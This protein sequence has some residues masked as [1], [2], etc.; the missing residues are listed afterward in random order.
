MED[1]YHRIYKAT[2]EDEEEFLKNSFLLNKKIKFKI[3]LNPV[4]NYKDLLSD[5]A[6]LLYKKIQLEKIYSDKVIA[7]FRIIGDR[8]IELENNP[9]ILEKI[10]QSE[11]LK[12]KNNTNPNYKQWYFHDYG[13]IKYDATINFSLEDFPFFEMDISDIFKLETDWH[14]FPENLS[15]QTEKIREIIVNSLKHG[16]FKYIEYFYSESNQFFGKWKKRKIVFGN[17]KLALWTLNDIKGV[18]YK[19]SF[20]NNCNPHNAMVALDNVLERIYSKNKFLSKKK[21][22]LIKLSPLDLE[23]VLIDI[24]EGMQIPEMEEWIE[25]ALF[26][27]WD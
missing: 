4:I 18:L 22:D 19:V 23:L 16:I 26:R 24:R 17:Y 25:D 9:D 1:Y 2:K 15:T 20:S 5:V 13:V 12:F 8:I 6:N 14:N 7:F 21:R 11:L 3:D 27:K 10:F